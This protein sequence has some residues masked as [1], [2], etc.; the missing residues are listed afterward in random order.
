[1]GNQYGPPIQ[2]RE[3]QQQERLRLSAVARSSRWVIVLPSG[4]AALCSAG[5]RVGGTGG[6]RKV[7]RAPDLALPSPPPLSLANAAFMY[8][9]EISSEHVTERINYVS[10]VVYCFK[11]NTVHI[12]HLD[13]VLFWKLIFCVYMP[14]DFVMLSY[15]WRSSILAT[16][17]CPRN[18]FTT[19]QTSFRS[20]GFLRNRFGKSEVQVITPL[21]LTYI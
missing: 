4:Y 21:W 11:L 12:Y 8:L 2:R 15:R 19:K 20:C 18:L 9:F 6:W 14:C 7:W 16:E 10:I 17:Y 5:R 13:F 3:A 1:M